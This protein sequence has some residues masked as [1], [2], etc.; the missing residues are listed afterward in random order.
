MRVH[1]SKSANLGQVNV[2]P[3]AKSY[4]LIKC[5]YEIKTVLWDLAFLQ[6][7]AIFRDLKKIII[8]IYSKYMQEVQTLEK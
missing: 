7:S 6:H 1:L 2:L 3:V 8:I 4:N 5:K